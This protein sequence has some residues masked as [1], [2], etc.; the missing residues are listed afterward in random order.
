[1]GYA[2]AVA[3]RPPRNDP[4]IGPVYAGWMVAA[5]QMVRDPT[6]ASR[7]VDAVWPLYKPFYQKNP[8]AEDTRYGHEKG[9]LAAN[10]EWLYARLHQPERAAAILASITTG[11]APPPD[12]IPNGATLATGVSSVQL[13]KLTPHFRIVPFPP[14][15]PASDNVV[16]GEGTDRSSSCKT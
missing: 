15:A 3:A 1:M 11:A 12:P 10:L 7:V 4:S 16:R 9:G 6:A 14:D 5:L 2:A 13:P 8:A